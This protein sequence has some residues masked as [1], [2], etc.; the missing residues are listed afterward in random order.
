MKKTL[1]L[2]LALMFPMLYS[3]KYPD[4]NDTIK[5]EDN[6]YL[7]VSSMAPSVTIP[8]SFSTNRELKQRID[9]GFILMSTNQYKMYKKMHDE[10]EE[11]KQMI[12]IVSD[13]QV[14]LRNKDSPLN[15]YFTIQFILIIVAITVHTLVLLNV[16]KKNRTNRPRDSG[17]FPFSWNVPDNPEPD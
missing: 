2:L 8:V 5:L 12:R 13:N 11:I 15:K 4:T 3:F 9:S 16:I 7:V 6:K 10:S 1:I 14:A 17:R